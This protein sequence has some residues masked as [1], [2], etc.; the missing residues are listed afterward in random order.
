VAVAGLLLVNEG[1]AH[2]Q[3]DRLE[4]SS[5]DGT[6]AVVEFTAV[7]RSGKWDVSGTV[8]LW[9]GGGCAVVH[10]ANPRMGTLSG[11][12]RPVRRCDVGKES[13]RFRTGH[14]AIEVYIDVPNAFDPESRYVG[15]K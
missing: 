4:V 5:Y 2:A 15:F 12:K 11:G 13:F 9:R 6:W 10:V 14:E 1:V 3:S 7:K 8:D